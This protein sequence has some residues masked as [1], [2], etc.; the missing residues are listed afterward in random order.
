M[1]L[2]VSERTLREK[3]GGISL[4]SRLSIKAA[5]LEALSLY[6][7]IRIY[8]YAKPT[9]ANTF[10]VSVCF[11]IRLVALG[12]KPKLWPLVT[13]VLI[14]VFFSEKHANIHTG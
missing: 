10:F 5:P 8:M 7:H 1:N 14:S 9:W 13:L 4:K 6:G 2:K 12:H 11:G 3:F